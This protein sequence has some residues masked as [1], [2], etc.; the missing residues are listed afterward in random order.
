MIEKLNKRVDKII[1]LY[2]YAGSSECTPRVKLAAFEVEPA[3]SELG[4]ALQLY[5][6]YSPCG[7]WN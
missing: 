4:S 6:K 1:T 5:T 3:F 7:L 2:C